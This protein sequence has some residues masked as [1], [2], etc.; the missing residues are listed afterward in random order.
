ML[1]QTITTNFSLE[2]GAKDADNA[3]YTEE[4]ERQNISA[5]PITSDR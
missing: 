5:R 2:A 4:D 1:V 3:E